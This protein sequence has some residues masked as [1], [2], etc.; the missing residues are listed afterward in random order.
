MCKLGSILFLDTRK[1]RAKIADC[2]PSWRMIGD[3]EYTL[4]HRDML[5]LVYMLHEGHAW[6][7]DSTTIETVPGFMKKRQ[8][9][10]ANI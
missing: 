7:F 2:D 3:V 10:S 4:I 6:P 9:Q 5:I 8:V 1:L